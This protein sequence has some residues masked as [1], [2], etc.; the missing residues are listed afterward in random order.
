MTAFPLLGRTRRTLN[1][2]W[3]VLADILSHPA[4][5]ATHSLAE[6]SA[7]TD[8]DN[9]TLLNTESWRH[10]G[11]QVAVSLLVSGVLGDE[12]EVF[13]SDNDRS[14]HL[15][16][17]DFAGQDSPSDGDHTGERALLVCVPHISILS[18]LHSLLPEIQSKLQPSRSTYRCKNPQWRSLVF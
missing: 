16:R 5:E 8:S 15:G 7:L 13:S 14:V 17:D 3:V 18:I 12:V 4:T 6:R 9:I 1:R 11:G 2:T 10:V